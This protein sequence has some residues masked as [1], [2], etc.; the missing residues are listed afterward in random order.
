MK[1][2]ELYVRYGSVGRSVGRSVGS[3]GEKEIG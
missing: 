2:R 3:E 1:R